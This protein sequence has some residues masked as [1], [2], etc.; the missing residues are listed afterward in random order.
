MPLGIKFA[1]KA[2]EYVV[3]LGIARL[4]GQ[5]RSIVR[6]SAAAA[7][8]QGG[9]VHGDTRSQL[10]KKCRIELAG[11]ISQP[12]D[13]DCTGY[14]S[15]PVKFRASTHIDQLRA[16]RSLPKRMRLAGQ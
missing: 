6:A 15:N 1:L 8:E 9:C 10:L 5:Y 2:F 13:L 14:A 11:W 12:L 7:D 16:W 4:G 3:A